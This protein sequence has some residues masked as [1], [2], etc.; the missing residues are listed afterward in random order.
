MIDDNWKIIGKPFPIIDFNVKWL[1]AIGVEFVEKKN[2][3]SF[4]F[5]LE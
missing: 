2:G 5:E 1:P 4:V 3:L